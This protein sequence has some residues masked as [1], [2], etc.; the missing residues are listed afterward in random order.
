MSRWHSRSHL[1]SGLPLQAAAVSKDVWDKEEAAK[2]EEIEETKQNVREKS[3]T[4][5]LTIE[6]PWLCLDWR[7]F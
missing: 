3:R 5:V 1:L 6:K 4:S 2:R 7:E